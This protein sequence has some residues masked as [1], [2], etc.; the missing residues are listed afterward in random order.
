MNH[1]SRPSAR[2]ISSR[3]PNPS[4][5]TGTSEL[6]LENRPSPP[7][8]LRPGPHRVFRTVRQVHMR[9]SFPAYRRSTPI[10][11]VVQPQSSATILMYRTL[12]ACV[13]IRVF[14]SDKLWKE[15]WRMT[16]KN[17]H[18]FYRV[19]LQPLSCHQNIKT[20][21]KTETCEAN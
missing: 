17:M 4:R 1:P 18:K 21:A 12:Y 13:F 5:T 15:L 3:L 11:F 7:E 19:T 16:G 2:H 9:S 8:L 6:F 20:K 14:F 10:A